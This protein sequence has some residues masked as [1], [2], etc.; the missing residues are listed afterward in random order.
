MCLRVS[1]LVERWA[2]CL[3]MGLMINFSSCYIT[4]TIKSSHFC[5]SDLVPFWLLW[6]KSGNASMGSVGNSLPCCVLIVSN[7]ALLSAS[8]INLIFV[9]SPCTR[10]LAIYLRHSRWAP[11]FV[12]IFSLRSFPMFMTFVI[13][14]IPTLPKSSF[15]PSCHSRMSFWINKLSA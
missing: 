9:L 11:T 8:R 10:K 4:E 15:N 14:T 3:N 1:G 12:Q 7:H 13:C 6:V 5:N 2:I